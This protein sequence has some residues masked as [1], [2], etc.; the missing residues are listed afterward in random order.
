[1]S[2]NQSKFTRDSPE[3][4]S[5]DIIGIYN[6][7]EKAREKLSQGASPFLNSVKAR[8]LAAV[9]RYAV[10]FWFLVLARR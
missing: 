10:R 7:W 1:M 3:I 8:A 6:G 5:Y 2:F 9:P 4:R